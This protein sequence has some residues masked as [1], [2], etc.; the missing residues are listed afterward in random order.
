MTTTHWQY[1]QTFS[2]DITKFSVKVS[3]K[4]LK[5]MI[6]ADKVCSP[7]TPQLFQL[8]STLSN[9]NSKISQYKQ[10]VDQQLEKQSGPLIPTVDTCQKHQ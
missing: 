3:H 6:A 2:I 10:E 7:P 9:K 4:L 1:A 5:H 8:T